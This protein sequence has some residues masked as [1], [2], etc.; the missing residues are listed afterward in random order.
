MDKSTILKSFNTLFFTF[1][2]DILT[3]Y[4]ENKEIKQGRDRFEL[5]KKGNPTVIIK[6]WKRYVSDVYREQIESGNMSFFIE[7]DYRADFAATDGW[8]EAYD[9]ILKSIDNIRATIRDMDDVNRQHSAE[10]L[11]NLSKLSNMYV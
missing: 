5:I 9:K 1:I 11:L 6:F 8:C 3:I 10:Y 4:P 2:D 7:K